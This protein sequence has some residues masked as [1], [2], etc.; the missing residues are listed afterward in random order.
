MSTN[1]TFHYRRHFLGQSLAGL[2]GLAG[3]PLLAGELDASPLTVRPPHFPA[4]AKRVIFLFML[5][6]PSQLDLFD[7]KPKLRELDGQPIGEAHLARM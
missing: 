7:D 5:G 4:K 6:G 1:S 2:A 3:A